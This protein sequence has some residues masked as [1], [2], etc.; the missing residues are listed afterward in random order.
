MNFKAGIRGAHPL[1][2]P[3]M[4]MR[5]LAK[6]MRDEAAVKDVSAY[7][8]SLWPKD[9]A[10]TFTTDDAAHGKVLYATCA[11]CH[12]ADGKGMKALNAP[13]LNQSTD[14]YLYEQ[15]KKFKAGIRGTDPKDTVGATMRPMALTLPDDQA[16]RDVAAYIMTLQR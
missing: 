1:D 9:K 7:V 3:G 6:S 13:P 5:P 14:W 12:G 2:A 16:M 8:A 10:L 4:R 15:L 11:A